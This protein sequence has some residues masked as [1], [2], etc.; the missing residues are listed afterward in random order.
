MY[1][2]HKALCIFQLDDKN[3]A[4]TVDLIRCAYQEEGKAPG[5]EIGRLREMVCQYLALNAAVLSAHTVF[6]DLIQ[7][8]G[9]F[10]RDFVKFAV[11]RME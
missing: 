1:K 4:D 6:M 10:V 2:L 11:Q 3:V 5:E 7:E 8:G 9:Q